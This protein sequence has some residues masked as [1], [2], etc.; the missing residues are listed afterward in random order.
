MFKATGTNYDGNVFA[1]CQKNQYLGN[2]SF[3]MNRKPLNT[4]I[5]HKEVMINEVE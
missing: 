5:N 2:L 4:Q 1:E 3:F